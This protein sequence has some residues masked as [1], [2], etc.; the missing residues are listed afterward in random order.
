MKI[1]HILFIPK[2]WIGCQK[3]WIGKS[4]LT[5]SLVYQIFSSRRFPS[6]TIRYMQRRNV[7][8]VHFEILKIIEIFKSNWYLRP[9]LKQQEQE[10][11]AHGAHDELAETTGVH[12]T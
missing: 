1:D 4:S 5:Y 11:D 10:V 7:I 8:I 3:T 9:G 6:G 2:S 12:Q